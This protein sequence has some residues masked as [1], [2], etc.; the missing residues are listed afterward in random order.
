MARFRKPPWKSARLTPEQLNQV[1]TVQ[2]DRGQ[3]SYFAWLMGDLPKIAHARLAELFAPDP[4]PPELTSK[5]KPGTTFEMRL[6]CIPP[7]WDE[8]KRLAAKQLTDTIHNIAHLETLIGWALALLKNA[9]DAGIAPGG[10]VGTIVTTAFLAGKDTSD[11]CAYPDRVAAWNSRGAGENARAGK[12]KKTGVLHAQN[13]EQGSQATRWPSLKVCCPAAC[14]R[15]NGDQY[16]HRQ[17]RVPVWQAEAKPQ[18]KGGRQWPSL[19]RS[20]GKPPS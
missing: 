1:W 12:A 17:A 13:Q 6:A 9:P 14:C 5:S 3:K 7:D 20:R 18:T 4:V 11:W 16:F 8:E 2:R 15:R 19:R 10:L